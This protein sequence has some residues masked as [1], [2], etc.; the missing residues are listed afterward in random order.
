[1]PD[2]CTSVVASDAST[3][4][5]GAASDAPPGETSE[6]STW[7]FLKSVGFNHASTPLLNR[8]TVTPSSWIS[9]GP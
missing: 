7:S 5:S 6:N 1:M 9:R 4:S 3:N 2:T 8:T